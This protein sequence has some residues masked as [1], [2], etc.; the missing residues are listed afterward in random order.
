MR[1]TCARSTE[2]GSSPEAFA[3]QAQHW[4]LG[5]HGRTLA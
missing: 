2:G 4:Q 1:S 3:Q 5:D